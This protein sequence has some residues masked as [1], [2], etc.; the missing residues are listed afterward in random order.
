MK[1]RCDLHLHSCLSPCGDDGATPAAVAGFCVLAGLD[2][3]ALSDHNTTKNCPAFLEAAER[4]GLLGIP[5]M[6]LTTAEEVHVL[7]LLPDMAAARELDGYVRARMPRIKNRPEVFGSQLVTDAEGRVL[8][9]EELLLIGASSIRIEEVGPLA[10]SLGGVAVPAHIDRASFSLLSNLGFVPPEVEFKTV[11]ITPAADKSALVKSNPELL[12][13]A[14]FTG[15]DAHRLEDIQGVG[16][17]IR[18]ERAAPETVIA[19]VK[20]GMGLPLLE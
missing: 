3:A 10:E 8:E 18:T 5:A 15:S 14:F 11:E 4:Y 17:V 2:A 20:T 6:E 7:C 13:R 19:A 12:G 16:T 9:A 1:L